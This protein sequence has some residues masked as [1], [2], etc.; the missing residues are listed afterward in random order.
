M[1]QLVADIFWV[2]DSRK[3]LKAFPKDVRLELGASLRLLQQGTVPKNSR[4]MESV[5][6]GI[7]ELKEQ[8]DRTWYRVIYM[9]KVGNKIFVLHCFEKASRKTEKT[10]LAIAKNRHSAVM[11][12]LREG[13]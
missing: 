13:K 7:W 4:R 5:G 11:A 8:D 12:L 1:T 9:A 2:G 6:K 10:D 3:V